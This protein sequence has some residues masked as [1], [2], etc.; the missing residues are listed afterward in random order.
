[1]LKAFMDTYIPQTKKARTHIELALQRH[2]FGQ[3]T[4]TRQKLNQRKSVK[5]KGD[6]DACKRFTNFNVKLIY[7]SETEML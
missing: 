6:I 2:T 7:L 5:L 1:M 3:M 4:K